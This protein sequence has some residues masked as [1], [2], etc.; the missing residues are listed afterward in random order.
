MQLAGER[1]PQS[2][3]KRMIIRAKTVVTMDGPPIDDGAVRVDGDRIVE[4]GKF[5]DL[6]QPP[7]DSAA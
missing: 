4:V 1:V 2:S 6:Y 7:P 3:E 5:S